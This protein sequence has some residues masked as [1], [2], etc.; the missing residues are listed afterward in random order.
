[1]FKPYISCLWSLM[2]CL[3]LQ[4]CGGGGGGE[5]SSAPVPMPSN[6][7]N[8]VVADFQDTRFGINNRSP[9]SAP[10]TFQYT[11]SNLGPGT[12]TAVNLTARLGPNLRL[13]ETFCGDGVNNAVCP[14]GLLEGGVIP[15][16]PGFSGFRINYR[17]QP[18]QSLSFTATMELTATVTGDADLSNN[19]YRFER[20]VWAADLAVS[21]SGP[22]RT[23][24]GQ[25]TRIMAQLSNLGPDT[26]DSVFFSPTPPSGAELVPGPGQLSRCIL[27]ADPLAAGNCSVS[28]F[29]GQSIGAGSAMLYFYTLRTPPNQTATL[30]TRFEAGPLGD[31]S[32][33]N[34][35]AVLQTQVVLP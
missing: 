16:L 6:P 23:L 26:A 19:S 34:N 24:A 22:T 18:V 30:Q 10:F 31:L 15:A 13:L 28:M 3:A 32:L 20:Q 12:A 17:V 35:A 4:S 5:A 21:V 14:A 9:V 1:M 11:V 33:A 8:L 29:T 2:L 7:F 27:I 25:E